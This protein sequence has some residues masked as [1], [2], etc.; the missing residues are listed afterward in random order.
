MRL[1]LSTFCIVLLAIT[2]TA[3]QEQITQPA[4]DAQ[5]ALRFEAAP[6]AADQ[7]TSADPDFGD[8]MWRGDLSKAGPVLNFVAPL[9]GDQEVPV[10]ETNGTGVAKLRLSK[11]GTALSYKLIAANIEDVT[12]AHIH[13]GGAGVNGPVVAFLF[14]FDEDGVSPNGIL[15]EGTITADD[16]IARSDSDVCPG[17][18]AD[19]AD[20]VEK[21]QHGGA[22]V[23]VHTTNNP[24]GE[25][26]GQVD[27]GNGARM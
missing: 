18:V 24:G 2:I 4:T 22:Y 16:V 3:C 13:C 12:Q 10:V 9:S 8:E 20:L 15:A 21:L 6:P 25:I 19:F 17:G 5:S 11:D 26:R 27:R 23:N 7:A 1:H 14:G